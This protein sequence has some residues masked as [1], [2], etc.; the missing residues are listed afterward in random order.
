MMR[1]SRPADI[2]AKSR[3]RTVCLPNKKTIINS[4][5]KCIATGWGRTTPDGDLVPRL[6][7][8]IIPLHSNQLCREKYGNS[9]TIKTGHLCG[10]QLDGSTG[11]CIVSFT[12]FELIYIFPGLP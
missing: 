2:S 3:I 12:D 7:E 8:A 11:T 9:V 10:G 4:T 5:T 1:L 6:Q